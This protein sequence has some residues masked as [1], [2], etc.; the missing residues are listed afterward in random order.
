MGKYLF[1]CDNG[2]SYDIE[3]DCCLVCENCTDIFYDCASPHTCI[4]GLTEENGK[5]S[6]YTFNHCCEN[7]KVE[8][9]WEKIIIMKRW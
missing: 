6:G 8:A 1:K 5:Q 7:F 4:C 3:N 9:N 2:Y